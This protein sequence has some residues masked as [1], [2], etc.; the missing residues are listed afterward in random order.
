M[1]I[2]HPIPRR[3]FLCVLALMLLPGCVSAHKKARITHELKTYQVV[4]PPGGRPVAVM[5]RDEIWCDEYTGGGR[6]LLSDPKASELVS[7]HTNQTALGGNSG[8]SIGAFQSEVSTNGIVAVGNAAGT[9]IEKGGEAAGQ[10]IN[11]SITGKP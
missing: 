8:L 3:I 9:I 2:E 6:A 1:N 4:Q 10:I 7:N 11:K 5:T